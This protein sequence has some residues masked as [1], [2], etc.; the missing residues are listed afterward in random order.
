MRP[1]TTYY[2]QVTVKGG[3]YDGTTS[4]VFRFTTAEEKAHHPT[5]LNGEAHAPLREIKGDATPCVP[6][7]L[8]WRSGFNAQ[9]YTVYTGNNEDLSDAVAGNAE[10][11]SYQP[12][13]LR[14]GETYYWRV[15]VNNADGT[16][17]K[18]SSRT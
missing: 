15:D 1:L 3:K 4:D 17:V 12:K 11:T 16:V 13:G 14:H 6:M 2:W 8:R 10:Q 5:P 18:G 9:S 7:S